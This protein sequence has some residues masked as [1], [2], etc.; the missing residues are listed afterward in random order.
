[1]N[2]DL[3]N[4]FLLVYLSGPLI[5]N[6]WATGRRPGW[7]PLLLVG[8]TK[9]PY[10]RQLYPPLSKY[11]Y[12]NHFMISDFYSNLFV[13]FKVAKAWRRTTVY[14]LHFLIWI[15]SWYIKRVLVL[16][17]VPRAVNVTT[18]PVSR[19]HIR[20]VRW[21]LGRSIWGVLLGYNRV[22]L[23]VDNSRCRV[24]K[25]TRSLFLIDTLWTVT[26]QV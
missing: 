25:V 17:T 23:T 8:L 18:Q 15:H 22:N 24:G 3:E 26:K 2:C 12:I 13:V 16:V 7:S 11:M 5:I 6:S 20:D 1:M 21:Y 14:I 10:I 4:S 19:W 9:Y